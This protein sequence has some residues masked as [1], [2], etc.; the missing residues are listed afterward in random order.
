MQFALWKCC[1][2]EIAV[3]LVTKAPPHLPVCLVES[4]P[5]VTCRCASLLDPCFSVI[6]DVKSA[7]KT[8]RGTGL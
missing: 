3:L 2:L 4:A 6:H 7:V 5:F 1:G 8:E